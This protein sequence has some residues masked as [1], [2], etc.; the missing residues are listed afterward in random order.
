MKTKYNSSGIPKNS[1]ER[2]CSS[3]THYLLAL[4]VID[5]ESPSDLAEQLD[6]TCQNIINICKSSS[7]SILYCMKMIN[8][9]SKDSE[10]QQLLNQF[11]SRRPKEKKEQGIPYYGD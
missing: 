11:I 5:R 3:D 10:N 4:G 2:E 7:R 8:H 9:K 1:K 6:R